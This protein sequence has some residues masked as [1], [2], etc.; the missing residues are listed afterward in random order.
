MGFIIK[1]LLWVSPVPTAP[2][3]PDGALGNFGLSSWNQC[4][5]NHIAL[6]S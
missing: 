5:I 6:E 3:K 2:P 1:R 4:R